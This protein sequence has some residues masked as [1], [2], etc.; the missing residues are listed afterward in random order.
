MPELS[1]MSWELPIQGTCEVV[2]DE[3]AQELECPIQ[4][5]E[6]S[7]GVG[8]TTELESRVRARDGNVVSGAAQEFK[9]P[10]EVAERSIRGGKAQGTAA[11]VADPV[12]DSSNVNPSRSHFMLRQ[13]QMQDIGDS[14]ATDQEDEDRA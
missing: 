8:R 13:Q 14:L 1:H 4:G 7:V 12:T 9:S 5:S 6:D 3:L 2:G 11:S 10:V